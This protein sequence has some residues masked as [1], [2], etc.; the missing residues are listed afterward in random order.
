MVNM[1]NRLKEL[2][3][4]ITGIDP[5]GKNRFIGTWEAV[6]QREESEK[7][8]FIL[9]DTTWRMPEEGKEPKTP[10]GTYY[11]WSRTSA[12]IFYS[13]D[14]YR[15]YRFPIA[16]FLLRDNSNMLVWVWGSGV[17]MEFVRVT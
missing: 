16:T 15:G 7:S 11:R 13:A 5:L 2:F 9:D 12:D 8:I 17:E 6:R 14:F 1:I 3:Y 10:P 4:N